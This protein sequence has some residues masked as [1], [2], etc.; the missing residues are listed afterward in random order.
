MNWKIEKGSRRLLQVSQG[1]RLQG[2]VP[3]SG[4]S[5]V[6]SAELFAPPPSECIEMA[7]GSC[8]AE[9]IKIFMLV[10]GGAQ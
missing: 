2:R 5:I 7:P 8:L 1:I 10:S 6:T 9:R 4:R 3:G